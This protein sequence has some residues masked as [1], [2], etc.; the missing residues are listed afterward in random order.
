MAADFLRDAGV[1]ESALPLWSADD[2]AVLTMAA[3]PGRATATGL[4]PRPLA[5]T[6]R[7]TLARA[8]SVPQ[9]ASQGLAADREADLLARWHRGG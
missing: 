2:P 7:D 3:D 8:Q 6:V 9:P 1:D 5:D 4:R